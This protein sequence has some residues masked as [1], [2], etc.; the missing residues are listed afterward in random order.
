M[1]FQALY[2]FERDKALLKERFPNW[3]ERGAMY[4]WNRL[5]DR[6]FDHALPK[7]WFELGMMFVLKEQGKL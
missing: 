5:G 2:D 6:F 4:G 7:E 1:G 3:E